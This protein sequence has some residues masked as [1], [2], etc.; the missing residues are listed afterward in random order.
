MKNIDLMQGQH[1]TRILVVDD[2]K[3][4]RDGCCTTLNGDGFDVESAENGFVGLKKIDEEHFDIILLDLMMP[5]LRGIDLLS[6]VKTKHPD[7]LVI[8]IT[9]YA[10]L[11]HAIDAMKKGAFDF[12]SKPF[13]PDD[14]RSVIGR[15]I[16]YIRTL[17]DIAYE[18]SRM[19]VLRMSAF[20]IVQ[21]TS[22]GPPGGQ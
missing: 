2:E 11:E 14:L 5:G 1:A 3:R 15:A 22:F 9:G 16:D 10:T 19:R 12:I 4:I 17:G 20:C 18:K 6:H 7:T 21:M 8:V 13:S